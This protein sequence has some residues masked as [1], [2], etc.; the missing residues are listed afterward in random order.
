MRLCVLLLLLT[1]TPALHAQG[2]ENALSDA[3]VEILRDT[4]PLP[5]DRVQAFI[6]FIDDRT[7]TIQTLANGPR[8]PGCEEDIHDLMEQVASIADDLDDNLDDYG[9]RHRDLRRVLP[10]LV[11]ATERWSSTLRTPAD[12][13]AYNVQR[14]LALE[15]VRDIHDEAVRLVEEQKTWFHDHPPGKE[16]K[17]STSGHANLEK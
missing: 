4:A 7:K 2:H 14:K 16:D 12:H 8:K 15:A 5:A 10:K 17:D 9:P 6:R 13:E 1:L 3:E 11:A